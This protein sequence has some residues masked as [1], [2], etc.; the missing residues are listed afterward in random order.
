MRLLYRLLGAV[1]LACAAI[2]PA[3][4][5]QQNGK[6]VDVELVVAVDI[7][8]SMDYDELTLQRMG[9]VEAFRHKDVGQAVASGPEGRIAVEAT[10][11]RIESGTY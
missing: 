5:S 10:L 4:L 9:Y 6:R 7:S 3:A 11:I 1:S 2:T 8:Q